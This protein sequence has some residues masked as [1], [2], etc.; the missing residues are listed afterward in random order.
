MKRNRVL[1]CAGAILVL[2]GIALVLPVTS[3]GDRTI[4]TEDIAHAERILGLQFTEAQGDS[5]IDGLAQNRNHY[6][7]IRSF[8]LDNDIPPS[9][10]FNPI[11]VGFSVPQ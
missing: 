5:M 4:T 3:A 8:N 11:P 7:S 1:L 2:G 10:L 6:E 9:L